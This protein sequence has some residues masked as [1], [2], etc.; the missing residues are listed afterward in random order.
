[1]RLTFTQIDRQIVKMLFVRGLVSE[2]GDLNDSVTC[3]QIRQ[4]RLPGTEE[5]RY[6]AGYGHDY[7]WY[8]C[9]TLDEAMDKLE[10][11]SRGIYE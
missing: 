2:I 11:L 6:D 1:M 5:T 4:R 7:R 8:R 10:C 9:E 3:W